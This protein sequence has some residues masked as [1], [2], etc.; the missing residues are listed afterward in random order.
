MGEKEKE[1]RSLLR[2]VLSV[3]HD[4]LD[5]TCYELDGGQKETFDAAC[6]AVDERQ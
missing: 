1:L 3:L 6:E 4:V 2:A 5:S